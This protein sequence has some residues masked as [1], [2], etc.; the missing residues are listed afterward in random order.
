MSKKK[1]V[2]YKICLSNVKKNKPIKDINCG[3]FES[4]KLPDGTNVG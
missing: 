2:C 4:N 3:W 1:F